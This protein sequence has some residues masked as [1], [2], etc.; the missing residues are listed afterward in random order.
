M[1]DEYLIFDSNP[2]T[3][4]GVA[5]D[6][7]IATDL[8]ILLDLDERS[9][10]RIVPNLA[11]IQVD[12]LRNPDVLTK[13]HVMSNADVIAHSWT[14]RPFC[15]SD[16]SAASSMRTTASPAHPSL[17]GFLSLRMHSKK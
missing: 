12:K 17:N 15:R 6:L 9:D 16:S 13:L 10:L 7:A 8:G 1:A 3:D 5:R 11:P 14:I 2:F 4:K